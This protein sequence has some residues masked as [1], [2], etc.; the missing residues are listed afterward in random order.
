MKAE[1][2]RTDV[3]V[4]FPTQLGWFGAIVAQAGLKRLQFG[5]RTEEDVRNE[6]GAEQF[7]SSDSLPSW[8][9]NA[10]N[11]LVDYAAGEFVELAEIPVSHPPC[12]LFQQRVIRELQQ[13][14]Y[15]ERITY[16][17]LA[18]RAGSQGAARAVGNL[19][20]KNRV[21]L[22]IPCHRVVASAGKLGGFSAPQ[23][24]V[25][26]RRLLEMEREV[27]LKLCTGLTCRELT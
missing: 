24:V 22:V 5:H 27:D 9:V 21:P 25:M 12:T 19:M 10:Q 2:A 26:K 20:A 7:Q 16:A 23:G 17:E 14:R 15:G 4:T 3:L 8:W 18:T 13:V 11:L 1:N 6:L